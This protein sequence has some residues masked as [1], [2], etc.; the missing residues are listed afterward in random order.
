[1]TKKKKGLWGIRWYVWGI[2]FLILLLV[3]DPLPFIDEI[4][5]FIMTIRGYQR[6]VKGA[7]K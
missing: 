5:L 3:P 6:E 2:A 7:Y 4:F 1:M